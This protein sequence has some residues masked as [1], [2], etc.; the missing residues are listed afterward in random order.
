MSIQKKYNF[1]LLIILGATA[2]GKTR[3]AVKIADKLN[4][5]IISADSR[6]IYKNLTIGTGKDYEE[7]FINN[8]FISYHLIDIL[9]V[10]KNYSVYQFQKDFKI[11]FDKINSTNKFPILCGGT[12]LYIESIL[13][14]YPLIKTSVNQTLRNKL[15][16]KTID[17]LLLIAGKEF[18]QKSNHSELN[19][20]RRIIRY[21]EKLNA[22][23]YNKKQIIKINSALIV[24]VEYSRDVSPTFS[25]E[26]ICFFH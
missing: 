18:I 22:N 24:G 6:Q 2:T 25:K 3:L 11:A 26:K 4:G 14:D 15:E 13:L 5:E 10:K 1:D 19:N 7:Y 8:K 17:E 21:I 12:G 20:K 23:N 16:L 9:D